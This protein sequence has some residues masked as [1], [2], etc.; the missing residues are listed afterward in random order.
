[1]NAVVARR[2][3]RQ[4][5]FQYRVFPY[6]YRGTCT[7]KCGIVTGQEHHMRI[8][9][10]ISFA[11]FIV[12]VGAF[13]QNNISTLSGG[14]PPPS[15][16]STTSAPLGNLGAVASDGSGNIHF[17]SDDCVFMDLNGNLVRVAGNS[18]L[19]FSGDGGAATSAQMNN[20][21]GLALDNAGN[22]Y[23]A[24]SGNN[25][26]RKVSLANGMIATIAGLAAAGYSGDNGAASNAALN[27]PQGLAVDSSGNL[28]IADSA[29]NVIRKISNSIITTVAG[30][31]TPG[32]SGDGQLAT[33]AQL[34]NPMGVAV[35]ASLNIYIAD[36][37]NQRIR[38]VAQSAIQSQNGVISTIAGIGVPGFSGDN[39]TA[40]SAQLNFP[41]A[42]AVDS[43]LNIYIDD[44]NNQRVRK[45]TS[46]GIITTVAGGNSGPVKTPSG[47]AVDPNANLYVDDS[48]TAQLFRFTG[49][50]GITV[51]AGNGGRYFA[52]DGGQATSAQLLQPEGLAVNGVG[53]FIADRGEAHVREVSGSGVISSPTGANGVGPAG[54]ALDSSGNV[55]LADA[56]GNQVLKVSPGGAITLIAGTGIA[57]A[58]GDN[59]SAT[60]AQLNQP[61]GVAV[62]A[63]GNVYIADT[64]NNRVR[65]VAFAT[66]VITTVAGN[67]AATYG[68]D[69]GV[70]NGAQVNQPADVTL[71]NAG[72][73]YIADTGNNRIRKI[74]AAT[75]IITT[76][77]GNGASA[78]SGDGGA[79]TSRGNLEPS[80]CSCRFAGESLY[81]RLC[82]SGP[83][84]FD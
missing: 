50:G 29:N 74:A 75:G 34:N 39:G 60:L 64:G 68:G 14:A 36:S 55:Y 84:G 52:G 72:N 44:F 48:G 26:I 47:I 37:N 24:D 27:N 40:R 77:A 54:V 62:D 1:M 18:R 67:G 32:A 13:A 80:R 66:G 7:S 16:I 20:P 17:I 15:N 69:N 73:L 28:Y 43:T 71:D 10:G 76:V 78:Y 12:N 11:F 3:R 63:A 70:S 83:Q 9:V 6:I 5:R 79:A 49:A 61:S 45:I 59:G 38:E 81:P 35:D 56:S 42:I 2:A 8:P 19:G 82:L 22:L 65:K 23:I 51:I 25:R 41:T 57:G 21:G 58:G 31:G 30:T 4:S 33:T 46:T 53:I